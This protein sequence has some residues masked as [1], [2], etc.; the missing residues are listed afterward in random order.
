MR[1]R[2]AAT[3]LLAALA[4]ATATTAAIAA[5]PADLKQPKN[6]FPTDARA[7][8]VFACMATNGQTREVLEKCSCSIDAIADKIDYDQYVQAET[9]LSIRQVQGANDQ[10]TMFR[11]SPWAQAMIDKMKEAQVEADFKCF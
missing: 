8:Y 5:D 11:S 9:V 3:L 10:V 7:D 1:H 6:Y 4:A 2:L